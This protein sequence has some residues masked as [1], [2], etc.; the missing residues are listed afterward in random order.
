[1]SYRYLFTTS[2]RY[3][4]FM[5]GDC[6]FT[7]QSQYLGFIRNGNEFHN[8]SGQFV[9]Y[10]TDD[11]RV[12]RNRQELPR[13]PVLRRLPPLQPLPP[14]PPLPRLPKLPLPWPYEDVFENIK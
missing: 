6:L 13:L 3:V 2:G 5:Y 10:V 1:M 9:G 12:V 7:P 11:D 14:L 4:A 8:K